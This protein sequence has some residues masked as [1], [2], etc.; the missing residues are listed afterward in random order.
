MERYKVANL[1]QDASRQALRSVKSLLPASLSFDELMPN[2]MRSNGE[3][4]LPKH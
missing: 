4:L 2:T 1:K 3:G